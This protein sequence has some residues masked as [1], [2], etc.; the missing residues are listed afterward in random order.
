MWDFFVVTF[1]ATQALAKAMSLALNLQKE[2]QS[3]ALAGYETPAIPVPLPPPTLCI[4]FLGTVILIHISVDA[5][6]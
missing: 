2:R 3:R 6:A 4:A 1:P 5:R